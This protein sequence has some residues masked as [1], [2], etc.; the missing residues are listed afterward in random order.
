[1]TFKTSAL[2]AGAFSAAA[3]L[4]L[5]ACGDN[6][7]ENG[8]EPDNGNGAAEENGTAEGDGEEI[9]VE[10]DE[11]TISLFGE[12][13]YSWIDEETGEPTGATIA[14][15][16]E[17]FENRL[18]Y[19]VTFEEEPTWDNL[20]PGLNA[21]HW[22]VVSAGM[23]INADRCEQ[24]SFGEPELVY[25]TAFLVADENAAGLETFDDLAESDLDIIALSGAIESG[26][27]DDLGIEH[28]TVDSAAD[29]VDYVEGGAAD[30]FALT[31][32]SLE[33]MAGDMEGLT[34]T[35]PFAHEISIG[36]H[37]FRHEDTELIDEFNAE[38]AD[39]MES[40]EYLEIVSE[41]GFTEAEMPPAGITAQELCDED[42]EELTEQ[43]LD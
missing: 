28:S 2:R 42:P 13:P 18:G 38:L 5:T 6:G 32:I 34:V 40:G 23:S 31:A 10:G 12:E 14:V 33:S 39:L 9:T 22:D 27:M 35:A 17:I 20:I 24:A 37:A 7:E 43:Y 11:L 36:A 3:L 25:T 41:F 21:G 16:E 26:W 4:V 29:G 15:A 8:E 19:N 1:M 30:V